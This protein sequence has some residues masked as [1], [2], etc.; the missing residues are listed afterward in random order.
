V[1]SKCREILLEIGNFF[2][3][4]VKWKIFKKSLRNKINV[5]LKS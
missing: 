4:Q 1:H 2:Q 3:V 5:C